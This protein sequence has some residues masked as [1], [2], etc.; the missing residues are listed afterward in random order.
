MAR[1]MPLSKP[2]IQEALIDLVIAGP[3]LEKADIQA[4]AAE[5]SGEGWVEQ[6]I[7]TFEAEFNSGGPDGQ[8]HFR[9][10]PTS[11]E[12]FSV[13][14]PDSTRVFQVRGDRLT[15]SHVRSYE[16]WESLEA[17]AA[18]LL[19]AFTR[20]AGPVT[21]GRMAARFINSVAIP[22]QFDGDW[23]LM[24]TRP[25]EAPEGVY[26]VSPKSF[27]LRQVLSGLAGGLT[28]NLAIGTGTTEPTSDQTLLLVDVDVFKMCSEPATFA[29]V[30]GQLTEI[31]RAK[32]ALFF[33]SLHEAAL[34]PY[35]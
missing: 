11:F 10:K 7:D 12:G 18:R 2:P 6:Q 9:T 24:L 17:D 34:E 16:S 33:G 14:S 30:Q 22:D 29:Q 26:G 32:N 19:E 8:M 5:V 15:A 20:R 4:I 3:A 28:A 25:P 1:V 35:R 21:I 27:F 13:S 31:R 23:S